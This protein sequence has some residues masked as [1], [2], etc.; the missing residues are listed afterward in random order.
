MTP[1]EINATGDWVR[2]LG[3]GVVALKNHCSHILA[4]LHMF[5]M[6][7][8]LQVWIPHSSE[9]FVPAK[10]PVLVVY[11]PELT[12]VFRM[13]LPHIKWFE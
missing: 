7:V 9:A 8:M 4:F 10:V 12:R 5:C 3:E 11:F 13:N 1:E 6:C 2:R